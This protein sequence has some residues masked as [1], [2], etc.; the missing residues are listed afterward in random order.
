M[1][2]ADTRHLDMKLLQLSTDEVDTS[3]PY[4]LRSLG[5]ARS[6]VLGMHSGIPSRSSRAL[7]LLWILA[8]PE[9]DSS[10]LSWSRL[11]CLDMLSLMAFW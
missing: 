9:A 11:A 6:L 4:I 3:K 7:R 10:S 5:L 1:D 2:D 8:E